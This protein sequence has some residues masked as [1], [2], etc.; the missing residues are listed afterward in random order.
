MLTR[1]RPVRGTWLLVLIALAF[2]LTGCSPAEQGA[3]TRDETSGLP[4]L[5]LALCDGEGITGVRLNEASLDGAVFTRGRDLWA[6]EAPTPQRLLQ[7]V[8]GQVPPGFVERVHLDSSL[9]GK[10]VLTAEA[11]GGLGA[12]HGGY[13]ESEKLRNGIL[14]SGGREVSADA[15]ER[16][17]RRNCSDGFLEAMGLPGW[18]GWFLL[19][20][21]AS[22]MGLG[23]AALWRRRSVSS[24]VVNT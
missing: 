17:A 2:S 7:F 9:P 24:R 20:G 21:V 23:V 6:I 3:V 18:L 16:A 4:A 5:V 10:M 12:A 22:A 15:L 19:G 1:T 14:L 8:V 13:F 11:D